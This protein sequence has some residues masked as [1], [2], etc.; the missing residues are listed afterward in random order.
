M[1]W[2]YNLLTF[3]LRNKTRFL[4]PTKRIPRLE[5]AFFPFPPPS[6]LFSIGIIS[7]RLRST[8]TSDPLKNFIGCSFSPF[9][10]S[11]SSISAISFLLPPIA[12]F[13]SPNAFSPALP[14][15]RNQ[16]RSEFYQFPRSLQFFYLRVSNL[17]ISSK[18][19]YF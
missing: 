15:I 3:Y 2:H 12:N 16:H 7:E 17:S 18:N 4:P 8:P 11:P 10:L 1:H 9:F 13:F 6:S 14:D 19:F 5:N